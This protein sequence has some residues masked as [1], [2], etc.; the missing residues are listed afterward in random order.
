[1][2]KDWEQLS[3]LHRNREDARAYY[4]PF[5]N[6]ETARTH[7]RVHSDRFQ[8]LNGTWK[9]AYFETP[10]EVPEHIEEWDQLIV[11]SNWQMHG[12]GIPHYTNKQ[13]PFPIDPPNVPTENPTGVF[14]R[15]FDIDSSWEQ[16]QIFL[17]FEGVDSA[18]H[19]WINGKEVGY[20]QGS[21][22]PAEFDITN[23]INVGKN[24]VTVK[25]YQ[26]SDASY[27]EDQDMWW[28]SGIF[29]DVYLLARSKYHVR[30]FF[31]Q[32]VL[33]DHY[34]DA[35]LQIETVLNDRPT[36]DYQLQYQLFSADGSLVNEKKV[37]ASEEFA[38]MEISNPHKWSAEDP[39]LYQL[40][41][42]LLKDGELV[43]IIPEKIGFRSVELKKGLMLVNG[44]AIKL[45]GVNRHDHHPD[46][47]KAVP[48]DWMI[49][50][51]KMMKRHN[52]N[53]VRTA[54]YPNDSRFYQLCNEYGL[55]VIDEADL[56]CHGFEY[57]GQPHLISDD[58]EWQEAYLDRMIRMVERD[59]NQ[60][61]IIMWSLGN[62]SGYGKNHDAMYQW[63]K[64]RDP[65]RLIHYEGECRT[66]MNTSDKDPQN[67]PVSSDVFTTMYTDIDILER[68]GK[69]DFLKTPHIVCEYAHAMGNSPGALKE[70][71]ETFYQYPR[72]QGGFVWEWMDHGIRKTT[73]DGKEYFAYG[74]D[75]GDQPNDSN[76]VMDGL[77]MSNH[78]P[79]PALLEYKKILEPV[80]IDLINWQSQK[81]Q[82]TNRYD[83]ITLNHLN[84][85]WTLEADGKVIKNSTQALADIKA[86]ETEEVNIP[87]SLPEKAD[88]KTDYYLN[89]KAVLAGDT[90]WAE[91]G[92]EV[93]WSQF[94]VPVN[95]VGKPIE[96]VQKGQ[97][98]VKEEQTFITV[99]GN[100]FTATFNK[101]NGLLDKWLM[102]GSA[103]IN[104]APKLN[105]WRALIDND[106]YETNQWKPVSNKKYWEQYGV[107]WLQHRLDD[108]TY[109]IQSDQKKVV[110]KATVRIAPPKLAW[111]LSVVYTYEIFASGDITV[112]VDGAFLG[113]IPETLPRIGLQ[114]KIPGVMDQ[115][116]WYGRGPGEAYV[117][118]KQANRFGIWTSNVDDLFTN[119]AV[120]Q[121]NGNRHEVNWMS[122]SSN[123]YGLLAI[124]QPKFDY[125]AHRYP[126]EN[127]DQAR[128]T[129]DLVKQDE[130]TLNINYQ[131]HGLG[132]ASCG[133]DVLEK[134]NLKTDNFQFN[135]RLVPYQTHDNP[136]HL[137]K[138][139]IM[140]M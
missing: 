27:I 104:E 119:Y 1:M 112:S 117:D 52:I 106:I 30:D 44:K 55:Y 83:F 87:F 140:D 45:K 58:R 11:P 60:P 84:L 136:V 50:D 5:S 64:D 23:Y 24:T 102:E 69:K 33:D 37:K 59:K 25:V 126:L 43:E 15:E 85:V 42:S 35:S 125:S 82:I 29:R 113:D 131:Q 39:Y 122:I 89:V 21:R 54:H 26:W 22:I 63:A 10:Q 97:L 111:S 2:T 94:E 92:Y 36:E 20:S 133:P 138:T 78:T 99:K 77:V 139:S 79:S 67:D 65:S 135:V 91:T 120:P 18:F 129:Y 34:K 31:V 32:T 114:M 74:G 81:L 51:I 132:S 47:G 123:S 86:G 118:S 75:F 13:Y 70:Y 127:L 107:H 53:A 95:S 4:I 88:F 71:W 115:V 98:Q 68:L 49:E 100:N 3:V 9:F 76:F 48:L 38:H 73:D 56:E 80:K 90:N 96:R 110:V 40:F 103:M 124:G 28:L 14:Q 108:F 134:Y 72:L 109:D 128:H 130:I 66:I 17:R 105:F 12:Y 41:I 137:A 116:K 46:H 57:I 16:E 93:A 61:S 7:Q 121:E 62:E 8:L 101:I 6:K 19:L